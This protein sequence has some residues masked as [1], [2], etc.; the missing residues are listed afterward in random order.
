[1]TKINVEHFTVIIN[2]NIAA[3]NVAMHDTGVVNELQ[4]GEERF[5]VTI[6]DERGRQETDGRK[7]ALR[8]GAGS[9]PE[10]V[11]RESHNQSKGTRV[12]SNGS[13]L[14][15]ETEAVGDVLDPSCVQMTENAVLALQNRFVTRLRCNRIGCEEL[16]TAIVAGTVGE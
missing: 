9:F 7:V 1:M 14:D 13:S 12:A 6:K 5:S 10:G 4:S 2:A 16:K 3:T 15:E 11:T 8:R